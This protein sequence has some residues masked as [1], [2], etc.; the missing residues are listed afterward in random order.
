V[1]DR[2]LPAALRLAIACAVCLGAAAAARGETV[3]EM[4]VNNAVATTPTALGEVAMI[5]R[6]EK[7][8]KGELRIKFH[9]AGSLP[10]N[11]TN[12]TQ[13]VADG[14]VQ[15]ADD[16]FFQGNI[17]IGGLLRLPLLIQNRDELDK[18]MAIAVPYI[19]A[20]FEKKGVLVLGHFVYP[21]QV[22]FTRRK[23]TSLAE[24]KGQK[25]R[26]TSPE[27]AEFVRR[28]GGT[29]MTLGA[30]EVP[31]ALDRGVIEGAFTAASGAGYTW[32]DLIKYNYKLGLN[33]FDAYVIVNKDAFEALSPDAQQK[34]RSI[35]AETVPSFTTKMQQEDDALTAKMVAENGM[36]LALPKPEDI[37]E[38]T[39]GI[40]TFW[41]VWAKAHGANSVEALGKIR[42]ALGR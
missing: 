34:L 20:A 23:L 15:I 41:N 21:P 10:I 2:A 17:P 39:R 14:V 31:A 36:V 1:I 40:E 35:V 11:V 42:A 38:A 5:E 9:L 33:F 22:A 24:I 13:A 37:A 25:L 27:Q 8:T 26:V 16:G 29:S 30:S 7:E 3:W 4:Y 6:I 12:T 28:F 32:R 18:A 19:E